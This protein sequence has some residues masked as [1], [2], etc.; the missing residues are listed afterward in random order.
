MYLPVVP[1]IPY[2]NPNTG[3]TVFIDNTNMPTNKVLFSPRLGFNYDVKGDN[4]FQLRGGS[5]LFTGRLPFV[6]IGNQVGNPNVFFLQYVDPDFQF[7]QVWRTNIGADY[8]FE[9]GLILT[10]DVSYTKD[11]NGAHVQNWGLLSPSGTLAGVDNRPVYTENDIINPAYVFTNSDKGRVWNATLKAQKTFNNGLYAMAAYNYL[12]AK[13]VNSI[14]AEITADAWSGNPIVG[15]ANDD[16]LGFSKYGDT[17]R[18]IGVASKK[19]DYGNGQW[20]STLSTFFEYAQGGRY[21]YTYGGDINGDGSTVNDLLYIPTDGE[22]DQMDFSGSGADAFKAY[23]AQDDYLSDR[24]GEYAERYGALAPWRGRWDLKFLQDFNFNVSAEKT[25]TLQFSLDVL[26]VGNLISS[27]WGL[28]QQ[29]S[30]V[31]PIGVTVNPE[32]NV[33]TYTFD[34]NL[35]ETYVYDASLMSRWQMQF[36]L[37]YIF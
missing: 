22:I 5:G 28:I 33:P 29:P 15:S 25:H 8:K 12:N 1:G 11:I 17:H 2:V 16:V 31:Q 26:N 34:G 21:S 20:S 9:N 37:R 30:N 18:F 14:E 10:G 35:I 6:W 32:T 7:P 19:W 13:D 3:E 36:G 27:E 4:T 23:I 24:R